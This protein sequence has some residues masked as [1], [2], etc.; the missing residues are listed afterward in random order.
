[1]HRTASV[2]QS[3]PSRFAEPV[4][5]AS[6][7]EFQ[8]TFCLELFCLHVDLTCGAPV[9]PSLCHRN[10]EFARTRG[11]LAAARLAAAN[12][13]HAGLGSLTRGHQRPRR[14]PSL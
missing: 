7:L 4:S 9:E 5:R 14:N 8:R 11:M 3:D 12:S 1:M 2:L 10:R 13:I 6:V